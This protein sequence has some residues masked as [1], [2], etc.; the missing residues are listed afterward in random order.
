MLLCYGG[1]TSVGGGWIEQSS[2]RGEF[3]RGKAGR[4]YISAQDANFSKTR[5]THWS[6]NQEIL[7]RNCPPTRVHTGPG[8]GDVT[9]RSSLRLL[10]STRCGRREPNSVRDRP[11]AGLSRLSDSAPGH[12]PAAIDNAAHGGVDRK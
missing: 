5:L 12:T 3:M 6:P 7:A 1:Q 8:D 2:G 4:G 10:G 9:R 11:L